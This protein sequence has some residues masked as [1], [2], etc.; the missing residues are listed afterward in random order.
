MSIDDVIEKTVVKAVQAALAP[1]LRRLADPAPL[2]YSV[3]DAAHVLGTS[4]TTIDRLIAQG[5]LP[6]VPHMGQRK[7]I[8]RS[9]VA[10]LVESG[11]SPVASGA[12]HL[13]SVDTSERS[14]AESA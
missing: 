4:P 8:P 11:A 3:K 7:L 6:L 14:T 12:P 13:T 5:V 2:V 10:R 9:A 1:Y